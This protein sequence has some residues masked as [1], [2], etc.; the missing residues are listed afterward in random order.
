MIDIACLVNYDIPI[1]GICV[2][3]GIIGEACGAELAKLKNHAWILYKK[4]KYSGCSFILKKAGNQ[5]K[6]YSKIS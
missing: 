3:H 1:P 5:E 4:R 2:G 6:K